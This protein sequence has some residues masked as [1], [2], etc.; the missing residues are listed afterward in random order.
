MLVRDEYAPSGMTAFAS[1]LNTADQ[2]TAYHYMLRQDGRLPVRFA[3]SFDL[4]RQAIPTAASAGFYENRGAMST[5][6]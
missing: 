2:V 4:A 1:R 3:Y 6:R 5:S